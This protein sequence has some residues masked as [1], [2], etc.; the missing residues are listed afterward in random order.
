MFFKTRY[1]K[2][3]AEKI[4]KPSNIIKINAS[5]YLGY[6]WAVCL[7]RQETCSVWDVGNK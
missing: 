3:K 5:R 4:N 1:M 2:G 7:Q 6:Y